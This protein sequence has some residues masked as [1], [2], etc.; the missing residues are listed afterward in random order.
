MH[1]FGTPDNYQQIALRAVFHYR[2]IE[3]SHYLIIF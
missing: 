1:E 3:L 2:I